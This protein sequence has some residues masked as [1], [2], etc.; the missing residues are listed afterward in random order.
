VRNKAVWIGAGREGEIEAAPAAW[1]SKA[2]L[3]RRVLAAPNPL[4]PAAPGPLGEFE[5]L[6]QTTTLV[7]TATEELAREIIDA[8][9]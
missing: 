7:A 5:D 2:A 3:A 1:N 9:A 4:E 8:L 6:C